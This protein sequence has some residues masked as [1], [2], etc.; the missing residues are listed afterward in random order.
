MQ[1]ARSR[2]VS[3]RNAMIDRAHRLS[4]VRQC[5]LLAV[6]RSTVYHKGTQGAEDTLEV[7]RLIDEGH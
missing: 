3:E 7:R 2:A 5:R 1:R 6:A 4:V